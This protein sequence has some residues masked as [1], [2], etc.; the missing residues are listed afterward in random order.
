MIVAR[1]KKREIIYDSV[2]FAVS[3][4][5]GKNQFVVFDAQK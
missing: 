3:Y 4:K 1:I 2:V 5:S